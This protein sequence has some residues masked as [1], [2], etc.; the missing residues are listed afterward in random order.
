MKKNG[1]TLSGD[2]VSK[3]KLSHAHSKLGSLTPL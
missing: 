3:T 2:E 1:S